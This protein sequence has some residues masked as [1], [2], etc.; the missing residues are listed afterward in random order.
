MI[1]MKRF[2]YGHATHPDWRMAVS[3]V[4]AQIRG[5]MA[6]GGHA[7]NPSLGIA[8]FSDHFASHAEALLEA[9]QDEFPEVSDWSGAVGAGVMATHAEYL[10]EPALAVMLLDL[11][12]HAYRVF[13]GIAPLRSEE[14]VPQGASATPSSSHWQQALVHA[15]ANLPDL[16]DLLQE[17]AARTGAGQLLGGLCSGSAAPL[18]L[19]WSKAL[20]PRHSG[21]FRGGMS[22]LAF[23]ADAAALQSVTQGCQPIGGRMRITALQDNVLLSLDGRPAL[24]V[25][26]EI[27]LV[28]MD[29]HPELATRKMRNMQVALENVDHPQSV[30]E[31]QLPPQARVCS[32]L[33]VDTRRGGIVLPESALEQ[34]YLRFCQ[35]NWTAARADLL[36]MCAELRE[37]LE[38]A[39]GQP[40]LA[41]GLLQSA[42]AEGML[43]AEQERAIAGAIYISCTGRGGGYFGA[44]N[45]ELELLHRVLGDIPLIGF[46]SQGEIAGQQLHRYSG[47]LLVFTQEI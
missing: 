28:R 20:E 22:G 33:G 3:L 43:D 16:P 42:E 17:L 27:M 10:T 41:G 23:G 31:G 38:P 19:A 11:P 8:Y 6:Q 30:Y 2:P 26:E 47:A 29:T 34:K 35:R 13:S 44:E 45:G 7:R 12:R 4:V 9:L 18:Q 5:R 24:E 39:H 25:L 21:V 1:R 14:G 40:L 15:D 46:F 32:L 36:R 37:S